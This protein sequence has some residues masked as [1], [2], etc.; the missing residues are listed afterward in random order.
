VA[1]CELSSTNKSS[2]EQIKDQ[3][4]A[5]FITEWE[6]VPPANCQ[7]SFPG[8]RPSLKPIRPNSNLFISNARFSNFPGC[9]N[10]PMLK[11][12]SFLTFFLRQSCPEISLP[13][14][15]LISSQISSF[16]WNIISFIYLFCLS[17]GLSIT[18][19]YIASDVYACI[20]T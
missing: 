18:H 10:V 16:L 1:H 13:P 14:E 6:F 3:I 15:H 2:N 20:F 11:S 17:L 4:N 19:R 12:V 7:P 5:V 9:R 8:H